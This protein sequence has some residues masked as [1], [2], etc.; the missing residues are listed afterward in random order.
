MIL[1]KLQIKTFYKVGAIL[2]I[3]SVIGSIWSLKLSWSLLNIGAKLSGITGVF[4]NGLW[5]ALFIFLY[6]N[7]PDMP[8]KVIESPEMDELLTKLG[9]NGGK[10]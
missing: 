10:K 7:T 5:M 3:F 1:P 9:R 2:M 8:Q 6:K 4:F